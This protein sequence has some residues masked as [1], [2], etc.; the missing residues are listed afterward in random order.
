MDYRSYHAI[1]QFVYHHDWIGRSLNSVETWFVPLFGLAAIALWFL[2]RPGAVRK[3]KLATASALA[4]AGL[5]LL[6]AQVIGKAWSRDRP[7][8]THPSAHVWGAR[9][10]DPSF[11]SDHATAAFAIASAILLF[12]ATA[13]WIFVAAA[14]AIAAGRVFV[15]V[16]YPADV[17]AGALLGVASAV[18]VV[19]VGRPVIGWAVRLVERLTDP[20]VAPFWRRRSARADSSS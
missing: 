14:I 4:S 3:W 19:R 2:D 7:F 5:A 16:H 10:H 9:S 8:V 15:G 17:L 11:P 13:G 1:N 12:D 6:V 20:L 18:F